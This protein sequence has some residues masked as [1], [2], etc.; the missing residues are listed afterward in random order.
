MV[1]EDNIEMQGIVF[2]MLFNIMFCVELENGY[3]VIVYIFGKMCKNYICI[4]MGD[5]VI[6]ELILYDLSKGCI[7]FCSC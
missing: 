1:K 7:V 3:V 6:V 5:K 4:L 2:E